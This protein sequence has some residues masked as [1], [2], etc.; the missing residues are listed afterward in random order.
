MKAFATV[1]LVSGPAILGYYVV[2][3]LILQRRLNAIKA[4]VALQRSNQEGF[5][6]DLG[7]KVPGPRVIDSPQGVFVR[8]HDAFE[9]AEIVSQAP[10]FHARTAA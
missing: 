5:L 2:R 7:V 10:Q 8:A 4:M 6:K 3:Y 9:A 1:W